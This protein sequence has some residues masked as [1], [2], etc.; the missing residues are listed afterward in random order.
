MPVKRNP[1]KKLNLKIIRL[2]IGLFALVL[3]L[4]LFI[5]GPRGTW[6]LYRTD[7]EKQKLV[8]E[9]QELELR[10]TELDSERT[11]LLNDP[12]YIEKIA[13][14]KYNMKKKGEKVFKIEKETD[15]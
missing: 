5:S 14:E 11:R 15:N 6:Q 12:K 1:K 3:I 10:K 2:G 8:D 13:R 4:F 9:I 7:R